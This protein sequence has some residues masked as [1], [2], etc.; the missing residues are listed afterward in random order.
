MND[1]TLYAKEFTPQVAKVT[2]NKRCTFSR[3]YTEI[4]DC[5]MA[6]PEVLFETC[7]GVSSFIGSEKNA[8]RSP[9][10]ERA[11]GQFFD[12]GAIQ[13]ACG[14]GKLSSHLL[15]KQLTTT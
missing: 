15:A 13:G 8:L 7:F 1:R 14:S 5:Y 10:T 6:A 9:T 4:A 12:I 11:G 3:R 2:S